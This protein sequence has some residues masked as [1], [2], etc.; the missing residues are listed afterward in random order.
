METTANVGKIAGGTSGNVIPG[1][2]APTG[3]S[4][5]DPVRVT[6]VIGEMTDAMIWPPPESGIE[7]DV[8][9]EA[10]L[11]ATGSRMIKAV[12]MAE[13]ALASRGHQPQ[14][15]TTGGG[16]G[17]ER[18]PGAA[19]TACCSPTAHTP[20]TPLTRTFPCENLSGNAGDLPGQRTARVT[21]LPGWKPDA[22]AAPGHCGFRRATLGSGSKSLT[23]PA[24]PGPMNRWSVPS[25]AGEVIVNVE[26][27]DLGLG[28]GGFDVIHVNLTW[29]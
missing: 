11:P 21:I 25:E 26:A 8:A 16:S 4:S 12:W 5:V 19:W 29:A 3:E 17:R 18:V 14:R 23:S 20:T 15:I 13:S 22:E 10:L 1:F 7:I 9:T 28:S 6:E 2:C 24:R 27:L